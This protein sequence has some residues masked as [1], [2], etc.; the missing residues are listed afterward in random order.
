MSTTSAPTIIF[1]IITK[2]LHHKPFFILIKNTLSSADLHLIQ[3]TVMTYP[4]EDLIPINGDIVTASYAHNL[5]AHTFNAV[6][7]L[8]Y[9]F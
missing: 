2:N 3:D 5:T 9:H 1:K 4:N 6:I 7:R 8:N